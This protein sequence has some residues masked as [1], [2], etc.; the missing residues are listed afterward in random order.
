MIDR[1]LVTDIGLALLIALPSTLPS[2]PNPG[3]S[4][5]AVGKPTA[6]SVSAFGLTDEARTPELSQP[7]ALS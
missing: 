7:A 6:E 2:A 5:D 4:D 1:R 3:N